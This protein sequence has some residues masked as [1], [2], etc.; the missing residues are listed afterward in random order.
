[1]NRQVPAPTHLEKHTTSYI[2]PAR[3]LDHEWRGQLRDEEGGM[4]WRIKYYGSLK[5]VGGLLGKR[6]Q[7]IV[8]GEE[9]P[10]VVIA[11]HPVTGE[12][13]VLFDGDKHGYNGMFVEWT[14]VTGDRT[15]V[16]IYR[17]GDGEEMF[18][19]VI[20][21][22]NSNYREDAELEIDDDGMATLRDGTR[23]DAETARRDSYDFLQIIVTNV[24]G[25]STAIVEEEL[26]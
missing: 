13:I 15:P 19:V 5:S 16:T 3:L 17:D 22:Y 6:S 25:R 24:K 4:Q 8:G 10:V 26:A 21:V 2:G 12:E 11:E 1:M 23:V 20:S 7:L 14:E 9:D 18:S